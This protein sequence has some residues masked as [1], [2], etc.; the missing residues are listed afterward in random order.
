MAWQDL[1]GKIPMSRLR[2]GAHDA[3]LVIERDEFYIVESGY[4]DLFAVLVD[5]QRDVL[6]RRP[7]ITR[8]EVGNVFFGSMTLPSP[9]RAEE[10]FFAFQ[11]VPS[12]D[13]VLLRGERWR[14][15]GR[16]DFDL[17]AIS[18]IDDWVV[19]ASNF[20]S[21]N[22]PRLPLD[23]LLLEA[24]PDVPYE[25]RTA[26]S[27]HH[28][29]VL[30]VVAD[31]PSRFVGRTEFPIGANRILS[32]TEHTWLTLPEDARVSAVHTPGVIMNG[33]IWP[34]LDRFNAQILRCAMKYWAE[35]SRK[36][37]NKQIDTQ[38]HRVRTNRAMLSGLA[39]LLG[40][41]TLV[42]DKAAHGDRSALHVAAA[43]VAESLGVELV[44]SQA[45]RDG[46]DL[47]EA[48]DA[49]VWPSGIRTRRV[50]LP[51]GW[52]RRDGPSF[53]GAVSGEE[54]RPVAVINRGRG[55]YEMT[56]AVTGKTVPVNR[57]RAESLEPQGA[58]FYPPLPR[59][60]NTALAAIL[61]VM[62]GRGRDIL[63]V[64]VMGC[65]GAIIALLTPIMI[66]ELLADII[67]RVEVPM[68]IAALAALA[69]G[70]F[71][72]AAF[73]VV[74]GFCMLRIEARIDE[75]LQ[76]AVWSRLLALPLSFFRRYLAGDL[77]D[78]ANGV[79]LVRQVL[80]GAT[81]S[82]ILSGVFS[83]F[84]YGLLFY[85]SWE[86]ALWA[87][88]TVLVLAA[89][90]WFFA[91]H[92]IRHQRAAFMAQGK[93]DGLVFQ[94]ILGGGQAPAGPCRGLCPQALVGAIRRAEARVSVG[95]QL[96][97]P[98]S[99]PSTHCTCRPSRSCCWG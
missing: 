7:F 79:T 40:A 45:S 34:A 4:V 82:S 33:Q 89:G 23:A 6:M 29:E 92:Q 2:L 20:V 21:Y 72:S 96:G 98:A 42:D 74:G 5:D 81:S 95:A 93:I 60:V 13:A 83:V 97:R 64:V 22:E 54:P 49:M 25:A 76:S 12:R 27:A 70:A 37:L 99:T 87:G 39:G 53:V 69:L 15:A 38:R 11:A 36:A 52:E 30:W 80:T 46:S 24:D 55:A 57:Q 61:H 41:D 3:F 85:Y 86:L 78:R 44:D 31:R 16:D 48:V 71:A 56:D 51:P 94:M 62:R 65:L 18:L 59:S 50:A 19:A 28:L 9:H 84:S 14:L 66:G 47:L 73:M 58:V 26:L 1:I 10:G 17:D 8:I 88:A 91:T 77:A 90:T 67:P 43:I 63:G 75:T 35:N 32:L 68:W